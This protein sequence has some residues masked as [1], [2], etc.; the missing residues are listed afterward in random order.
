MERVVYHVDVNSAYLSWEAVYRL[1]HLGGTLDLRNEAAAVGGDIAIRR[2]IIL[3]KSIK[4]KK[5][6]VRTGESIMEAKKKCPHLKIVP[7]NYSLYEKCSKAMM[8]ILREYSPTVEQFSIDEAYMDNVG[9]QKLFGPPVVTAVKIKDRIHSELGFTVNIGISCNKLLAKMASD[10]KKPDLVHTLFPWE[11]PDKM[12]PLPVEDLFFVGRATARKLRNLGIYTI[13]QLAE[14]DAELLR[15]HLKK[16]GEVIWNFANGRD[17]SLVQGE[18]SENKGYGNST[19]VSFERVVTSTAKLVLLA[20]CETVATRLRKAQVK[21]EVIS[22]SIKAFDLTSVS[23]QETLHSPTDITSELHRHACMLFDQ[24]WDGRPIRHLGVH[25]SK[26]QEEEGRQMELF[27]N[28]DYKKLRKADAAVD[29]IRKK[30]GN[31]AVKRAVFLK[32]PIDH[33]SGG[34]SREK[35]TVDYSKINIE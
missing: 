8:S 6:G 18:P 10:F 28:T 33:L 16:H 30:Y 31:D 25:T 15:F 9:L 7:P 26:M 11:I 34:I 12:W 1:Y 21:A 23:H 2:G 19:T 22:V 17:V 3:A 14:A 13:G 20:L 24:L 32:G 5:C 4:A 29:A 27:D 35:R